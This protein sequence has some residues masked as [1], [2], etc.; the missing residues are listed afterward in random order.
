V[1]I[2]Y[3]LRLIPDEAAQGRIVGEVESVSTGHA[4]PIRDV[5]ELI[6]LIRS[7]QH[8]DVPPPRVSEES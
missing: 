2:S 1:L 7:D 3:V 8:R 4:G 5:T 6:E